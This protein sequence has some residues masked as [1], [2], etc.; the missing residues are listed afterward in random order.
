MV[1]MSRPYDALLLDLDGT[2]LDGRG[3][4]RPRNLQAL[5]R[6]HADGIRVMVVTGRSKVATLPILEELEIDTLSVLFNGAAVYCPKEERLIEER[7]LSKRT[8]ERVHEFG[9]V[10]DYLTIAMLGHRKLALHPRSEK[11]ARSLEGLH[12]LEFV[13]REELHSEFTVRVTFLTDTVSESSQM[14]AQ[15]EEFVDQ[16]MYL[17]HFPL[18]VLASHR[19]SDIHAVD[20]HPPCRGKAEALRV[21]EERYGIPAS[22]VVAIGDATNDLPMVAEAGLGVAVGSG[23][24]ELIDIADRVIGGHDTDAIADLVDELWRSRPR[25][26]PRRVRGE[27]RRQR[28]RRGSSG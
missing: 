28:G 7:T 13:N 21:L 1:R 19:T 17:T 18:S 23:M 5:R 10:Y 24:Q 26:L 25:G 15:V 12:G 6:A 27:A 22:R 14:A 16:P 3:K 20:V 2:L 8:L 4:V 11:E 9:R